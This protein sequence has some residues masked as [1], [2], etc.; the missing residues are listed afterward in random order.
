MLCLQS[1]VV[2]ISLLS[3]LIVLICE[4]EQSPVALICIYLTVSEDKS[5]FLWPTEL[6]SPFL[7]SS[8]I[9]PAIF[10]LGFGLRLLDSLKLFPC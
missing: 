8:P 2:A 9:L 6:S 4:K 5:L 7:G 10:S 3:T 1:T